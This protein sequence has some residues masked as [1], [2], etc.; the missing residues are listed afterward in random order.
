MLEEEKLV[1]DLVESFLWLDLGGDVVTCAPGKVKLLV[2]GFLVDQVGSVGE[3]ESTNPSV[4]RTYV[5]VVWG[6]SGV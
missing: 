5:G 2:Q 1:A 3:I 6:K 4:S